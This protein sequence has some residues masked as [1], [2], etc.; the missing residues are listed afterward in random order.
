MSR[1]YA[2]SVEVRRGDDA[3][4][5]F[6]WRQR[7]YVVRSVLAHWLEAGAWWRSE[8]VRALLGTGSP[9]AEGLAGEGQE[10]E[11]WR[12]EAAG[13]RGVGL[14]VYDLC[15]DVATGRWTLRALD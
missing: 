15:R 3:P 10:R 2:D 11:L 7:V 13:G 12:V 5:Q 14:G 8:P 9:G 4:Q 6:L 1:R